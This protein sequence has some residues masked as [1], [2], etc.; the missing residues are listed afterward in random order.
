MQHVLP[1]TGRNSVKGARPSTALLSS[2]LDSSGGATSDVQHTVYYQDADKQSL[3]SLSLSCTSNRHKQRQRG[4]T[5][6]PCVSLGQF[7]QLQPMGSKLDTQV[8]LQA[9]AK[10]DNRWLMHL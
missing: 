4:E 6:H 2:G 3:A 5:E 9:K 8:S 10:A 7:Q 1:A